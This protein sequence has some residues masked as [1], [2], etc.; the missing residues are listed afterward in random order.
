MVAFCHAGAV[1]TCRPSSIVSQP[2]FLQPFSFP[3][4]L[5]GEVSL[6]N[7]QKMFCNYEYP[8]INPVGYVCGLWSTVLIKYGSHEIV[9]LTWPQICGCFMPLR[10]Y[11][12]LQH[13]AGQT[14]TTIFNRLLNSYM[15]RKQLIK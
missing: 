3:P 6:I 14:R 15:E 9:C 8:F 10:G 12:V 7:F 2:G 1:S 4:V 11:Q 5:C 13:C